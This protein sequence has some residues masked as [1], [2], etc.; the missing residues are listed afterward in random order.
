MEKSS[1]SDININSIKEVAARHAQLRSGVG[2]VIVE[3]WMPDDVI[4]KL[5][6]RSLK[7]GT[8]ASITV[9]YFALQNQ[10]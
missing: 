1:G 2:I 5:I 3:S 7:I 10:S 6:R 9:E 8:G 4:G